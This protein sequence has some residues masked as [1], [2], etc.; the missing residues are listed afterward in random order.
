MSPPP[1]G[2]GSDD[3]EDRFAATSPQKVFLKAMT[4]QRVANLFLVADVFGD[5]GPDGLTFMR[6]MGDPEYKRLREFLL[7]ARPETLKF[8]TDL[9]T[10]EVAD[11]EEA[12]E[13]ARSLKRTGRVMK[14]G[15]VTMAAAFLGFLAV[16]DKL[17]LLLSRGKG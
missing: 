12:I 3:D 1:H 14:W 13:T 11:I 10:N 9:R 8:L 4:D 7:R 16:W 15:T 17:V 6:A 5:M 2:H